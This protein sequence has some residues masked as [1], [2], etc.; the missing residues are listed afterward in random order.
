MG[1]FKQESTVAK[2]TKEA[3]VKGKAQEKAGVKENIGMLSDDLAEAGKALSAATDFLKGVMESCANKAMSY[4]ERNS[5]AK[6]K[7]PGSRMRW[8][9]SRE[10]KG[11]LSFSFRQPRNSW[12]PG[13]NFSGQLRKNSSMEE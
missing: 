8:K 12:H 3:E 2:S 4:E 9:S 13:S 6:T 7:S 10:R 11:S 5:D 1:K